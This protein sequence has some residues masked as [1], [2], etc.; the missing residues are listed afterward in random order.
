M[1]NLSSSD[2]SEVGR[3][4]VAADSLDAFLLSPSSSKE[5]GGQFSTVPLTSFINFGEES[6]GSEGSQSGPNSAG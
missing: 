2:I 5:V 3:V 4:A 6:E 1:K